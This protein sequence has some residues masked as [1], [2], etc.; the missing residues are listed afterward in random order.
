MPP[1]INILVSLCLAFSGFMSANICF[2]QE[3]GIQQAN[4]F[5]TIYRQKSRIRKLQ[6]NIIDHK[7]KV[8]GSKKKE[9]HL[10]DEVDRL[11]RDLLEQRRELAWARKKQAEQ[12]RLIQQKTA[13]ANSL[14]AEK[15]AIAIHVKKRLAAYYQMGGVGLMNVVFSTQSLP[16][17][18]IFQDAFQVLLQADKE[19]IAGYMDKINELNRTTSEL[20]LE[21]KAFEDLIKKIEQ[22]EKLLAETH[23]EKNRLLKKVHQEKKLYRKAA[24]EMEKAAAH[25]AYDLEQLKTQGAGKAIASASQARPEAPPP[26]MNDSFTG[27]KGTLV[28][29]VS[30]TVIVSYSADG[31]EKAVNSFSKGI[32]IQAPEGKEIRAVFDGTILVAGHMRNYGNMM[33]IDHG[34]QYFT[35]IAGARELTRQEGSRVSEGEVIGLTGSSESLPDGGIHFEIRKGSKTLAPLEWLNRNR[36]TIKVK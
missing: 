7:M 32:D 2:A 18:L 11:N 30:G 36:L 27:R 24:E 28:P 31:T 10:L 4:S 23:E 22:E 33:I 20:L 25:L 19:A 21:K 35:M 1:V 26:A 17:L 16:D 15:N 6:E 34:D 29:P 3:E 9:R 13:L 14:L 8:L 12:D 5:E